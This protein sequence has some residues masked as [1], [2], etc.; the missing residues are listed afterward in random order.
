M[1]GFCCFLGGR[2]LV[3]FNGR[4]GVEFFTGW[5]LVSERRI[6]IS[7]WTSLWWWAKTYLFPQQN[8]QC[9][10]RKSEPSLIM[11]TPNRKQVQPDNNFRSEVYISFLFIGKKTTTAIHPASSL[12]ILSMPMKNTSRRTFTNARGR[13]RALELSPY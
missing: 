2:C 6:S 7:T 3:F 12:L 13:L 10:D 11:N 5:A 4:N 8:E 9:Q 1:I